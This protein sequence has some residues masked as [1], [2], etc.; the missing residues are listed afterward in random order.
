MN[1]VFRIK[2][3]GG[4]DINIKT[5]FDFFAMIHWHST[6]PHLYTNKL[7]IAKWDQSYFRFSFIEEI[8]MPYPYET[9]CQEY[10]NETELYSKEDCIVKYYQRKEFEKCGCNRKWIYY[11]PENMT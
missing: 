7:E 3:Y 11:N 8:L 4:I 5:D 9:D 1:N 2:D 10:Y 6:P